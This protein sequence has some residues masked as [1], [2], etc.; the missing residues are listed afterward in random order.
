MNPSDRAES[1]FCSFPSLFAAFVEGAIT[2]VAGV[3]TGW[4]MFGITRVC[5]QL[6]IF[7]TIF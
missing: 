6:S 5:V 1:G 4:R 2:A 3:V 7:W